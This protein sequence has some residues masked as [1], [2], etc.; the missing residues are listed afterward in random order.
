MFS[1]K[2]RRYFYGHIEFPKVNT[3]KNLSFNCELNAFF[4]FYCSM[5]SN[6]SNNYMARLPTFDQC[7][8]NPKTENQAT[9]FE[10][11][12]TKI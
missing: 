6:Q 1:S 7:L 3:T 2:Y 8:L 11:S 12:S 4:S 5:I 9:K 10:N